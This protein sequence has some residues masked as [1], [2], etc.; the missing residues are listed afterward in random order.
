MNSEYIQGI[1]NHDSGTEYTIKSVQHDQHQNELYHIHDEKNSS[2]K[3]YYL[4]VFVSNAGF[5]DSIT[6][7]KISREIFA[8]E[9]I[10]NKLNI[11]TPL[12]VVIEESKFGQP[13][14]LQEEIPGINFDRL[15]Y[16]SHLNVSKNDLE[17]ISFQS[18]V[19][20]S[21]IHGLTREYFGDI[22]DDSD[23][24]YSSWEECFT[25]FVQ[26]RLHESL[27][28]GILNESQ[29]D[30][31]EKRLMSEKLNSNLS[32]PTFCHRDYSPQN[33][34][35]NPIDLSISGI[36]DFEDASY[37]VPEWDITRTIASFGNSC[38]QVELR[39]SFLS[40]YVSDHKVDVSQ[41]KEQVEYYSPFESLNY[42]VWGW[43]RPKFHNDIVESIQKIA[44]INITNLT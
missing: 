8:S 33:I 40:G 14:I 3:S 12:M 22:F 1:L 7:N 19:Y 23:K 35:V 20:L 27:N 41:I 29:I 37:W 2:S 11:P 17:R 38:V 18:G 30:Y 32:K 31:F 26:N 44:G 9:I 6:Q 42:W 39:R 5:S 13:A 34:I 16:S 15:I 10:R 36:I 25:D 4:K 28:R 43:D 21:K 24:Y